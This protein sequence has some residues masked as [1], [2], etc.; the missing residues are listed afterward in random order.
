ML[1][2]KS[3][4][5]DIISAKRILYHNKYNITAQSAC[6]V[7][8]ICKRQRDAAVRRGKVWDVS[9]RDVYSQMKGKVYINQQFIKIT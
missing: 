9:L 5:Y 8:D 6:A 4:Y 3:L 1:F 2:E 7:F